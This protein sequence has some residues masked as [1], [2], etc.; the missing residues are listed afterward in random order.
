[1]GDLVV[2]GALRACFVRSIIAH[3]RVL[4]IDT[5]EAAIMPEVADVLLVADLGLVS[6][7]PADEV[8]GPFE[9]PVLAGATR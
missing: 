2:E 3:G 9:R 7:P 6:Q 4:G 8:D 1:M 5:A